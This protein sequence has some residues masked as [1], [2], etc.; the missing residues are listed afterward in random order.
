M[1]TKTPEFQFREVLLKLLDGL[2]DSDC[3]K[4]KFLLGEDIPR[5]L[6]DDPTIGGTLDL[7]QK[8]FDQHKISEQN[9]TYLI[10]A[11]EAIKCFHAAQCL[12]SKQ[13]ILPS[14]STTNNCIF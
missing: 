14:T 10:N 4:L 5:R 1:T 11:F 13:L 7:F 2:S 6:Q 9:F 8:L 12:K 3:K